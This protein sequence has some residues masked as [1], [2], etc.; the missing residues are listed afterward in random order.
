MD[1]RVGDAA[2]LPWDARSFSK[3]LTVHTIYFW[4]EPALCMRELRRVVR[5][6]GRLVVGF[7]ERSDEALAAFPS[8]IYRLF[9]RDEVVALLQE[10]GFTAELRRAQCAPQLWLAIAG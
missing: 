8:S 9:A 10:A 5:P 7:R 1:L 3:A 2:G 4:R 6:G